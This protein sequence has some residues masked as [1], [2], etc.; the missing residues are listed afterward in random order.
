MYV[1]RIWWLDKIYTKPYEIG[2]EKTIKRKK[3]CNSAAKRG[4]N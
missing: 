4:F 3:E 1:E 2:K